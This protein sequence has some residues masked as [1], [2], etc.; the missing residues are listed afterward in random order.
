MLDCDNF[1][2]WIHNSK[3]GFSFKGQDLDLTTSNSPLTKINL[4]HL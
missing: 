1:Q 3:T 4:L 2:P